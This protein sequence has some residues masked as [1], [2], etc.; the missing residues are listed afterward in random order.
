[1][2]FKE[3]SRERGGGAEEEEEG[4]ET[5]VPFFIMVF[6]ADLILIIYAT[7]LPLRSGDYGAHRAYGPPARGIA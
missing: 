2:F 1:M 4:R 7:G 5:L 3:G 6:K